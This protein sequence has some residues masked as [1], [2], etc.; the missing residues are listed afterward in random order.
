MSSTTIL[1]HDFRQRQSFDETSGKMIV[2]VKFEFPLISI[3]KFLFHFDAKICVLK[4]YFQESVPEL[5][6]ADTAD[7]VTPRLEKKKVRLCLFVFL[8]DLVP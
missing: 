3:L 8:F 6:H 5:A 4:L 2:A 7:R 1:F